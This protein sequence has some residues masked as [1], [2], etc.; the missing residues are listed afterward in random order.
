MVFT[1][2]PIILEQMSDRVGDRSFLLQKKVENRIEKCM[3][4]KF[5]SGYAMICYGGAGNVSYRNA[6]ALSRIQ[7]STT[8][9]NEALSLTFITLLE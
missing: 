9:S 2:I 6:Y 8:S 5:R 7:V 1:S 3:E 4:H